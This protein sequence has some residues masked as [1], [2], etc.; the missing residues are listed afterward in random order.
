MDRFEAVEN[1]R[2]KLMDEFIKLCNYND[3][4]KINLLTIGNT[5]DR[6]YDEC[7]EELLI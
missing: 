5:V 2:D 3:Y 7:I 4:G 1:F 6:I